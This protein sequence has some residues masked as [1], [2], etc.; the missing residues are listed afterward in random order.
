MAAFVP[1]FDDDLFVS[2]AHGDDGKW[3][4]ALEEELRDEV[5][6]RLGLPISIWQ[7]VHRIRAGQNWQLAI[8]EGIG[9][10][11]AFL[12]VVSPRYQ[13]SQ[14][15]ARERNEFRRRF[16]DEQFAVS[17]RFFKAVKTPWPNHGHRL[18][19]ERS[20][21]I[22]FY[23]D[24]DDGLREFA[25]GSRDFKRCV[26]KL[27]DGL[28]P[29]L[30]RMRRASQRVH[31]AWPGEECLTAWEQLST[32]LRG[33]GF[34]VQPTG[35][36]DTSFA[37]KLLME[38]MDRAVLSIHLL[39]SKYDEFS[40]RIALLAADL[41]HQIMFWTSPGAE[42]TS[43]TRQRTLLDSI[44]KGV[45]PDNVSAEWPRGWS[46]ISGTGIHRFIEA[47]TTRLRPK[48]DVPQL[49]TTD[50]PTVYIVHDPTTADDTKVALDLKDQIL[51]REKMEVFVSRSDFTSPTE[52]KLWHENLLRSCDGVLLYRN[53]A[54]EGWWNQ[55]APEVILAERRFER[56]PIKSRA[57]LLPHPPTWEVGPDV[58]LIPYTSPFPIDHLEPFLTPLRP[59]AAS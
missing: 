45:R 3:V 48:Q 6:R 1:G 44:R 31:V 16:S 34:D 33:K 41:E 55:L 53:A 5:S 7:D 39:G 50:A 23:K 46:L 42:S 4:Q 54:P 38:D 11:A 24:D 14:W 27:A 47:V 8:E 32:E 37:D 22:D 36:R 25:A 56:Q 49:P 20:P 40:E 18:F 15:C 17:G 21:D 2:Y 58:K 29:L 19:L 52:F 12:A 35:P 30:R 59:P 43:D 13:N 10:A 26:R 57:F 9:H 51:R 28:E